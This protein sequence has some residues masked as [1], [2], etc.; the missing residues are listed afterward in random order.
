MEPHFSRVLTLTSLCTPAITPL[1]SRPR[2]GQGTCTPHLERRRPLPSPW[3]IL[4]PPRLCDPPP[5]SHEH[6]CRE[7]FLCTL[8][9]CHSH[10][11]TCVWEAC[12]PT[13]GPTRM[14]GSPPGLG[15][16]HI[17]LLPMPLCSL[18]LHSAWMTASFLCL[19]FPYHT[20]D[21]HR[22]HWGNLQNA[23]SWDSHPRDSSHRALTW[24]QKP[25]PLSLTFDLA[26]APAFENT[27]LDIKSP[28]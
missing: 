25:T 22:D 12:F 16:G 13:N 5:G 24:G 27:V 1:A 4:Q 17:S 3:T 20:G 21:G 19:C 18:C 28:L 15:C 9:T 10:Y 2:E 23:D 8:P 14:L 7:G 11:C 26:H 6:W